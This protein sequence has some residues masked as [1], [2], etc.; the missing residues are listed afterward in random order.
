M[1]RKILRFYFMCWACLIENLYLRLLRPILSK[2]FIKNEKSIKNVSFTL[3]RLSPS[4]EQKDKAMNE[5]N[6][7]SSLRKA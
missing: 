7:G 1:L 2:K 5:I 6:N 3:L 4:E